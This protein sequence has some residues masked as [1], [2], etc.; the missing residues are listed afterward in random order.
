MKRKDDAIVERLK[1]ELRGEAFNAF[2]AFFGPMPLTVV[3]SST[4]ALTRP[5]TRPSTIDWVSEVSRMP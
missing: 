1:F 3:N 4:V 2:N 5:R